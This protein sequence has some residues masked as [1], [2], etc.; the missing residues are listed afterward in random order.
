MELCQRVLITSKRRLRGGLRC[1]AAER[2][3]GLF[4]LLVDGLEHGVRCRRPVLNRV[5]RIQESLVLLL[6]VH[7]FYYFAVCVSMF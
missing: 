3:R 2:H 7:T 1:S 6:G 5:L 4:L